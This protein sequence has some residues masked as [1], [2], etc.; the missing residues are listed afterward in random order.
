MNLLPKQYNKGLQRF[1]DHSNIVIPIF[2]KIKIK[3]KTFNNNFIKLIHFAK[4]NKMFKVRN[5]ESL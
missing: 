4:K 1:N 3:N 5:N 2:A